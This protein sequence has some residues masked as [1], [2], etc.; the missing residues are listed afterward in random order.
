MRQ[1]EEKGI[2]TFPTTTAALAMEKAAKELNLPGR[3]IP[4]PVSI[5]ASCGLAWMV[6]VS[7]LERVQ[8]ALTG[9]ELQFSAVQVALI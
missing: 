2:V 6:E 3:L 7:E 8:A 5:T 1:K 4:V 9:H